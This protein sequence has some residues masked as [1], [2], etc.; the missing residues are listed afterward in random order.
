[1]T[2]LTVMKR[3]AQLQVRERP[4]QRNHPAIIWAHE[5][6]KMGEGVP[7]EVAWCSSILNLACAIAGAPRS[8]SAAAR[9]WLDPSLGEL[10][11]DPG[12]I[13]FMLRDGQFRPGWDVVIFKRGNNLGPE[14]RKG[15]GHV[16]LYED[17]MHPDRVRVFGGN[18]SNMLS[19][20]GFLVEDIIAVLRLRQPQEV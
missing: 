13:R 9:S 4:G 3:F 1:M 19:S 12:V 16:A 5:L 20:A 11:T 14:V 17:F 15:P 10:I 2:P 18:Q 6:C 8:Q 7:D